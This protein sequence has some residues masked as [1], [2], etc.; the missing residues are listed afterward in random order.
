MLE[1]KGMKM[2]ITKRRSKEGKI[3]ISKEEFRYGE[4]RRRW[5]WIGRVMEACV[6]Q[7]G[8]RSPSSIGFCLERCWG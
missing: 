4:A 7:N 6:C 3:M 8:G 2:K 1:I 5:W